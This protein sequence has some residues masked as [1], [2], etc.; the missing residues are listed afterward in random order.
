[1]YR[2]GSRPF[3]A[4]ERV[5]D[6]VARLR[7]RL[8][9][10]AVGALAAAGAFAAA[11]EEARSAASQAWPPFV[12]VAG[13]L[14][15]G[16]IAHEGR[17]FELAGRQLGRVRG[18][19]VVLL[20]AVLGVVAAVTVL[21]NLDT[22]AAFVTPVA[23]LAARRR[24][25]RDDAFLYGTL[26]M[27]NAA[28]LLLPGSNLT[29]LLVLGHEHVNGAT[30]AARM[31]PAWVAAV[32]VT[33]L[34]VVLWRRNDLRRGASESEQD[35]GPRVAWTAVALVAVAGAAVLTTASPAVP[36]LA[37]AIAGATV[38]IASRR[39]RASELVDAV[40][41]TVLLA[42]FG[43]AITLG[44]LARSWSAP[45]HLLEA[46]NAPTTAVVATA[47]AVVLNNLPSAVL[48]TAHR[49]AHPRALLLGLNLG[50]NLAVT[51][52]LSAFVW[53]KAARRVGA[54][55]DW[56]RVTRVGV[57]LV[58]LSLAASAAALELFGRR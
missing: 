6:T 47:G 43:L 40:D 25:I 52:S 20:G 12:L 54:A 36:V 27:V 21:L 4:T 44:A 11:P 56:R 55:P 51:G 19:P 15:I 57:V 29:N 53:I 1:V 32:V 38:A 31:L 7:W 48:F 10:L 37:V 46:A 42:L 26:F 49:V 14:A 58:P 23:I 39:L 18:S 8:T 33:A 34:V 16:A 3:W 41:P 50:P 22:A 2:R 45:G 28:S 9:F 5:A 13:L 17:L 30:F 35:V 24:G